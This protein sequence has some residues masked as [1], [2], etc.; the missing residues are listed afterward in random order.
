MR[1][2]DIGQEP[3][4]TI[5]GERVNTQGSRK[6]KEMILADDYDG[7]LAVA[8]NNAQRLQFADRTQFEQRDWTQAGWSEGLGP[9]DLILCNPPY[10]E[11]SYILAPMVSAHE[12]HSAL[13]A[14][15]D[16]LNDYRILIPSLRDYLHP[17][18]V[19]FF[20]IGYNQADSVCALGAEL[21]YLT[22]LRHD[23]GGNPRVIR[24]SLGIEE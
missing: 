15:S 12:P 19:A 3:R 13:F 7:A 4:P 23:F 16:V 17:G 18:G 8:R 22:E 5:V 9:F 1:T 11:D 2:V 6:I 14:G 24:F 10:I 21:G 20:E